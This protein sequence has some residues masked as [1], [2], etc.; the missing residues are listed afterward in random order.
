M[1]SPWLRSCVRIG[2]FGV[3]GYFGRDPAQELLK[4]LEYSQI[5][6][7]PAGTELK[8]CLEPRDL[9]RGNSRRVIFVLSWL[10]IR[11]ESQTKRGSESL[12]RGFG[13]F[14]SWEK[15]AGTSS[16]PSLSN[17]SH[18]SQTRCNHFTREQVRH[19]RQPRSRP[20]KSPCA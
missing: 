7:T 3:G 6:T 17:D 9:P 11:S 14:G 5:S 20:V 18:L 19:E 12:Q 4:R 8:S 13:S 10:K 16:N 15:C 2:L 1:R